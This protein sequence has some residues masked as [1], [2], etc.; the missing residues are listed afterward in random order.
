MSQD[1]S[2]LFGDPEDGDT[3]YLTILIVH[4]KGVYCEAAIVDMS[5]E[6][7]IFEI[8]PILVKKGYFS[9]KYL[10]SRQF[11]AMGLKWYIVPHFNAAPT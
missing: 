7:L 6:A 8:D 1:D 9:E 4:P 10:D 5:E 11:E 3:P 2:F